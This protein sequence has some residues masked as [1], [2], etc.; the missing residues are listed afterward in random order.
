M[1]GNIVDKA[2]LVLAFAQSVLLGLLIAGLV[3]WYLA[4]IPLYLVAAIV[5]VFAVCFGAF[6]WTMQKYG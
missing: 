5:L 2:L 6:A 4:L 3:P 1:M